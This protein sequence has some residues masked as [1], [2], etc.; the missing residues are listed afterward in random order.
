M[1]ME[2]RYFLAM[3][4]ARYDIPVFLAE[5]PDLLSRPPMALVTNALEAVRNHFRYE[6]LFSCLKTGS[7]AWIGTK[8]TN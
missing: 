3:A 2:W 8:L 4:M 7:R 1:R 5:K 6:D